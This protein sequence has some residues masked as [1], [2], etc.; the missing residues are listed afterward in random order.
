MTQHHI[1]NDH[2]FAITHLVF[3][4]TGEFL[5]NTSSD[6]SLSIKNVHFLDTVFTEQFSCVITAVAWFPYK[7]LGFIVCGLDNSSIT[8]C[9]F[10]ID[11][12]DQVVPVWTTVPA[13]KDP[14]IHIS[15][16]ED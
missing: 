1:P 15:V 11:R 9:T 2:T 3:D 7:D 16:S 13:H 4:P 8:I 6:G 14:L 5:I 10:P 12:H